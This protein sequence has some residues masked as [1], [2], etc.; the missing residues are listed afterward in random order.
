MKLTNFSQNI[1]IPHKSTT[2]FSKNKT[3]LSV[4]N[5]EQAAQESA[6]YIYSQTQ[7]CLTP[8]LC[9]NCSKY[10]LAPSDFYCNRL[11]SNC[12]C[13]DH[14]GNRKISYTTE[15]D[16]NRMKNIRAL[17][18]IALTVYRCPQKNGWHLTSH[19]Q[20]W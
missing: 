20:Y 4:Y 9:K 18:G 7:N 13:V 17:D 3:P 15:A 6:D 2:C 12:S 5:S 16:A 1:Y 8:Y 19:A 10:H 11:T 14:S